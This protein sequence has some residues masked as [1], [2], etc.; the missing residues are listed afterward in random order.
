MLDPG[1]NDRAPSR[2][3]SGRRARP[4]ASSLFDDDDIL[5]GLDEGGGAQPKKTQAKEN[6]KSDL[7]SDLFG[8]SGGMTTSQQKKEFVLDPKYKAG[9][10]KPET[11]K[12]SFNLPP[13]SDPAPSSTP[14]ERPRRRG[15]GGPTLESKTPKPADPFED[16]KLF[17]GTS[18]AASASRQP[19]QPAAAVITQQ[20]PVIQQAPPA[21]PVSAAP[22]WFQGQPNPAA[23]QPQYVPPV[24]PSI[25]ISNQMGP[26]LQNIAAAHQKQMQ[27]MEEMERR[28]LEQF[29]K[30]L[31]EQ[32]II[33]ERKQLEHQSALE[34]QRLLRQD[35]VKST[36]LF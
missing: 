9:A 20:P 16:D 23:A 12:P 11:A 33:L 19:P 3:T 31:M 29:Q 35:Q 21:Q 30:D 18:L 24:Q 7:M 6:S 34:Q 28:Q 36:E 17:Q 5:S 22:P 15:G 26:E 32:K 4:A 8:S 10:S 1:E 2:P 25:V 27:E 13:K 14:A